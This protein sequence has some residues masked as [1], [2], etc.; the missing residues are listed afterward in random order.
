MHIRNLS[1]DFSPSP[2]DWALDAESGY[3]HAITGF[4]FDNSIPAA[5]L[6]V[7]FPNAGVVEVEIDFDCVILEA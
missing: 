5:K 4:S 6:L 1:T 2:A 7:E 3:V